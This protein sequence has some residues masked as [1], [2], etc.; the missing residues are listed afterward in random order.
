MG[1]AVNGP[2]ELAQHAR[3]TGADLLST[4]GSVMVHEEFQRLAEC[5]EGLARALRC[6][7]C[8]G[9]GYYFEKQQ[10]HGHL[11]DEQLGCQECRGSGF[12]SEKDIDWLI[13]ASVLLRS[14]AEND[15]IHDPAE[16]PWYQRVHNLPGHDPEGICD[17]GCHQ[18]PIC[19]TNE[20]REGWPSRTIRAFLERAEEPGAD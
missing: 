5:I 6:R 14:A 4:F 13:E 12:L 7:E 3:T 17:S 9:K 20:P 18:E 1:G 19:Q 2:L 11:A 15:S 10:A 8:D 16:C